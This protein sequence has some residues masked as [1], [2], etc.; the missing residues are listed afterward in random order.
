MEKNIYTKLQDMRV[1]LQGMNI[2]KTGKNKHMNYSYYEL[3]DFMPP[4]NQLMQEH[5]VCGIVSYGKEAATLTLINSEKPEEAL[6]FSSPMADAKL[7]NAHPIQNLG[8]VETYQRRYLYMTA[9]EIVEADV[10]DG[11]QCSENG[12]R[13]NRGGRRENNPSGYRNGAQRGNSGREQRPKQNNNLPEDLSDQLNTEIKITKQQTGMSVP[14]IVADLEERTGIKMQEVTTENAQ[15]LLE[16]LQEMKE[17]K[18][19]Y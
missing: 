18:L 7:S 9:F 5:G 10:L 14:E 13:G 2:K 11:T 16:A 6:V 1:A 17:E 12:A 19:P 8:A 3:G 4:I 15:V